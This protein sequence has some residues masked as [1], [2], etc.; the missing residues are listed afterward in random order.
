[1]TV[2]LCREYNEIGQR[3]TASGTC[4]SRAAAA[5]A[6]AARAVA[7]RATAARAMVARAV[8]ARAVAARAA[9]RAAGAA[10]ARAVEDVTECAPHPAH[11]P[12]ISRMRAHARDTGAR[13]MPSGAR[14]L[15]LQAGMH[16]RGKPQSPGRATFRQ[17]RREDV[18]AASACALLGLCACAG[19]SHSQWRA[20]SACAS[21]VL[22]R[23]RRCRC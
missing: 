9:A 14:P 22:V 17:G 7:A 8:V 15:V 16:G 19:P 20:E 21:L 6:A 11:A 10:A 18:A 23:L 1:M 5:R 4:T 12:L 3:R 2:R 13:N